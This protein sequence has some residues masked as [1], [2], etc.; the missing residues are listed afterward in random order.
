MEVAKAA[1]TALMPGTLLTRF[2]PLNGFAADR[3]VHAA[4]RPERPAPRWR[5]V[6]ISHRDCE[7]IGFSG[8]TGG[9]DGERG[10][11]LCPLSAVAE[12]RGDEGVP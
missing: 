4:A 6:P 9:E 8:A 2:E 11:A 5:R 7:K 12:F 3:Q 10:F 1:R